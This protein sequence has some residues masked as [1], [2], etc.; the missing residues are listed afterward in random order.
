M[1]GAQ[2]VHGVLKEF[3]SEIAQANIDLSKT[4]T[5]DYLG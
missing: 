2:A 3:T 5:N 1:S 4:F